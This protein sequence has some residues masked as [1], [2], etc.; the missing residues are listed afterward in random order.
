M[1]TVKVQ[2]SRGP[3]VSREEGDVGFVCLSWVWGGGFMCASVV[4]VF[5]KRDV[6][7]KNSQVESDGEELPEPRRD[8]LEV[9][10]GWLTT[11]A[12][13]GLTFFAK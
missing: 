9:F 13:C 8:L 2:N 5:W 4:V 7:T 6:D 10:N 12:V 1:L 3:F 11:F